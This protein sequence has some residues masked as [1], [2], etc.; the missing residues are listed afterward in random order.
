LSLTFTDEQNS[1]FYLTARTMVG[2]EY[3]LI[4]NWTWSERQKL[5][6][7]FSELL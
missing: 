6:N 5:E 7:I 3:Q 4:K 2:W 1:F